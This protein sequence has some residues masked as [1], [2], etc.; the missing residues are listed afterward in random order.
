MISG[1]L[2][3]TPLECIFY[4]ITGTNYSIFNLFRVLLSIS[5]FTQPKTAAVS[6]IAI[7]YE[8]WKVPQELNFLAPCQHH[9]S[10]VYKLFT[11]LHY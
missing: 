6:M 1:G 5:V 7:N 4:Y 10:I 3:G 11:L 9:Y 2:T 8:F